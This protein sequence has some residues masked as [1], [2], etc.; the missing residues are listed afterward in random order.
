MSSTHNWAIYRVQRCLKSFGDNCVLDHVSFD[1]MP[2]ETVCILGRSGV[3]S[4][5]PASHYGFLE[6]GLWA[7]DRRALKIITDYTEKN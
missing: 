1:V 5:Y 2:G 4:R 7:S 6:T 3:A